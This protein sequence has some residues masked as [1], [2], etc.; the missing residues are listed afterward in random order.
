MEPQEAE[1]LRQELDR[2][3]APDGWSVDLDLRF[4]APNL[5]FKHPLTQPWTFGV[6]PTS[7]LVDARLAV[8]QEMTT[9]SD[10][11]EVRGGP[12]RP[13]HGAML[14]SLRIAAGS[15]G[16]ADEV[17]AQVVWTLRELQLIDLNEAKWLERVGPYPRPPRTPPGKSH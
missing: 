3:L 8:R 1:L 12:S 6:G 2:E 5:I 15:Y 13:K 11:E 17:F 14:S 10:F 7:T 16:W 9:H 4:R